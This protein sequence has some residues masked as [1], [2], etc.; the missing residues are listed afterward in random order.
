MTDPRGPNAFLRAV[1]RLICRSWHR[2]SR[3]V[4]KLPDGP[5]ILVGN[6]IC[7]LDPLLI[8]AT[9]NR[10]LCFLMSR[11]YY[12]SMWYVRWGLDMVGVIP[13]NPGGANRQALQKAIEAVQQGNVLCIFPEGA[14]NPPIPLHKILP[15][16]AMIARATAAPIIP[17]RISGVW[18]F[19]HIHLWRPFYRRSRARVVLGEAVVMQEGKEGR[20][21]I[22]DDTQTIRHAIRNLSRFDVRPDSP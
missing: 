3:E 14:A 9:V 12:R 5:L 16:A 22:R 17:F 7:G 21:A 10:P 20:E 4:V 19:D 13:V 6:H 18:P 15:G 1:D 11:E 8:Q 2:L